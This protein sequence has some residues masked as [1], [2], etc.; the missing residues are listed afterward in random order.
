MATDAKPK[1]TDGT[2]VSKLNELDARTREL[3]LSK[4]QK[5]NDKLD[6]EIRALRK[7]AI[8]HPTTWFSAMLAVVAV[9]GFWIQVSSLNQDLKKAEIDLK[10]ANVEA[11]QAKNELHDAQLQT[12]ALRE[13][14]DEAKR[15]IAT[16]EAEKEAARREASL[17]LNELQQMSAQVD[18]ARHELDGLRQAVDQARNEADRA[19]ADARSLIKTLANVIIPI[20]SV[21]PGE[22][23]TVEGTVADAGEIPLAGIEIVARHKGM[24]LAKAITASDGTFSLAI[25]DS[26]QFDLAWESPE[27]RVTIGVARNLSGS[28]NYRVRLLG[29]PTDVLKIGE[30]PRQ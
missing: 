19:R 26:P 11:V 24:I 23:A 4:L 2:G 20:D 25:A 27:K 30:S 3:E 6:A 28:M 22:P 12:K 29:V 16:A 15:T 21:G 7:S 1:A 5:E 13:Q 8:L 9:G 10:A 18:D 14:A 17:A